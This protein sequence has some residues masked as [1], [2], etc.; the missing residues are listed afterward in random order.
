MTKAKGLAI[1]HVRCVCRKDDHC[2]WTVKWE[3]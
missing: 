1:K 3:G 2:E